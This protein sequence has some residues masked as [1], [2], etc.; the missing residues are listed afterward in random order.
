MKQF[1]EFKLCRSLVVELAQY[2]MSSNVFG[3]ALISVSNKK[4]L[5]YI[6]NLIQTCATVAS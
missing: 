2:T 6:P 5:N 1:I 3:G 4:Q